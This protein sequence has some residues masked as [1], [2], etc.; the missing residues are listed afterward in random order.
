M[1]GLDRRMLAFAVGGVLVLAAVA[2]AAVFALGGGSTDAAAVLQDAGCT[3][4]TKQAAE[5]DAGFDSYHSITDPAG[6]SKK[7]NTDPP[8]SGPHT[9]ATVVWGTY[10]EP[11]NQAQLVHN[12]EHGGVALQYGDKV[13][14]ATIQQLQTFVQEEKS[15]GTV[16]APYP[17]LG[18]KIAMGAWVVPDPEDPDNGTGHLATCTTFDKA[19]FEAFFDRYQFKGPE[20]FPSEMLLPGRQ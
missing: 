12:L 16:L 4:T 6:T 14:E 3:L 18:D 13:S 2:A 8:S 20:R 10:S 11:V 19:A 1:R 15:R 7:W 5:R 17:K 9:D